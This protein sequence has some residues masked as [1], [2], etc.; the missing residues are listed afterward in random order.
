M[1]RSTGIFMVLI[2][3]GITGNAQNKPGRYEQLRG[4]NN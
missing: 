2:M 3:L 4:F 1:K